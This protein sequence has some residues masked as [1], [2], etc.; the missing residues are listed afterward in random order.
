M[1]GTNQFL[2][3]AVG[4]G[5][6]TLTPTAYAALTSLLSSGFV[7][8]VA[9]SAQFNTALR[10]A[11]TA[12]AGLAQFIANQGINANDDG[13]AANF[14]A[15]VQSAIRGSVPVSRIQSVGASV[16]ANALTVT[17]DQTTLDF[18]SATQ[19]TG[20]PNTRNIPA[21]LSLTV[22]AGATLGTVNATQARLALV[23]IDNAGTV[24]LAVTNLAGGINLDETTL[25]S[26]TAISAGAT[27]ANVI[28]STTAR[29]N[30]PFRVVGFV[31]ITE[32]TAGT[33]ATAP[34]LVQG[35][36]GNAPKLKPA[37]QASATANGNNNS[38]TVSVSFNAPGPGVLFAIVATNYGTQTAGA[39]ATTLSINGTQVSVDNTNTTRVQIGS[40]ATAGGAVSASAT[41]A[42]GTSFNLWLTLLYVPSV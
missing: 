28:Y 32:A 26:T 16:A 38:Q 42:C 31:D 22:P 34:A 3:F 12:A 41:G 15:G 25:I 24:E 4:A 18:R 37:I 6:N 14:A 20:A 19:T 2:P 13:S 27:A 29:T 10:Q 21:Q 23:A 36:G 35:A 9:N 11:T 30:V 39:N 33:W 7:A 8:G 1:P 40:S 5:A 17:L